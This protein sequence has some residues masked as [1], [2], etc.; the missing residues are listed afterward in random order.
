VT[1]L[2]H[3]GALVDEVAAYHTLPV[4]NDDEHSGEILH[5]LQNHQLDIITF[6]SSSTVR[7]FVQWLAGCTQANQEHVVAPIRGVEGGAMGNVATPLGGVVGLGVGD[8]G[9]HPKIAC[10]GPITAQTA[11]ELGFPVHIQAQE[12]TIDG[13]IQAILDA[14]K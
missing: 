11:R 8:G 1:Q 9:S 13:L 7:N 4:A 10:I 14:T 5:L 2:Q 12:F 3:A 6:T